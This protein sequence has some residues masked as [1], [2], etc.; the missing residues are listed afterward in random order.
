MYIISAGENRM[1]VEN[2]AD[3]QL[4]QNHPVDGPQLPWGH[5]VDVS[6]TGRYRLHQITQDTK[7]CSLCVTRDFNRIVSNSVYY[8]IKSNVNTIL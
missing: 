3:L 6:P 4:Y 7:Y 2:V 5:S 1:R 8:R